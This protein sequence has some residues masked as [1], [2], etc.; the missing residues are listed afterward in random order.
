MPS[1]ASIRS[2]K[3]RSESE[4]GHEP[5]AEQRY[6]SL[7]HALAGDGAE[8]AVEELRQ[9]ID[10]ACAIDQEGRGPTQRLFDRLL[11]DVRRRHQDLERVGL[12]HRLPPLERKHAQRAGR[13]VLDVE[14]KG[15]AC[16]AGDRLRRA[17]HGLRHVSLRPGRWAH[18][19]R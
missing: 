7:T 16:G 6:R 9:R 10:P 2:A 13:Q 3:A 11:V 5:Q 17:I 15:L 12:V 1:S 18:L 14:V 4:L 19:P 8:D